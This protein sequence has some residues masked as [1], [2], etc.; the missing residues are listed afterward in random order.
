MYLSTSDPFETDILLFA[1]SL[2]ICE[3]KGA[4][5]NLEGNKAD[6]VHLTS[7]HHPADMRIWKECKCLADAGYRVTWIVPG[8]MDNFIDGVLV[9]VV[10][11]RDRRHRRMTSTVWNVYREAL[12]QDAR[13][14]HFHDPELIPAGLLLRLRKKVVYDVHENV[15]NQI[16]AKDWIPVALRTPVSHS[17]DWVEKHLVN[18]WSAIVTANED[19]SSRFHLSRSPVVAIHNYSELEDFRSNGDAGMSRYDSGLLVDCGGLHPRSSFHCVVDA[20]GLIPAHLHTRLVVMGRCYS[21]EYMASMKHKQGWQR[22]EYRGTLTR[23][24]MIATMRAAAAAL[25]LYSR[26]KNHLSVRSNRLFDAMAAGLPVIVSDFPEWKALISEV[27]CGLTV[28]PSSPQAIARA[29]CYLTTHPAE[30]ADMGNRGRQA[31][32]ERFNWANERLRLLSLYQHLIG[33]PNMHA[34]QPRM[35]EEVFAR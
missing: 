13:V 18:S 4:M 35:P 12:R 1:L 26:E 34:A 19:I 23:D 29:I 24:N 10:P 32:V 2:T 21:A 14:Y 6:V 20:L 27:G 9:K 31:A 30:A 15:A 11:K 5:T 7:V 17:Y 16:F 25:V 28:D 3:P 33:P 8:E 22:A